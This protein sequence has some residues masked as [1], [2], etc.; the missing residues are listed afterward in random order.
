M[1]QATQWT[2]PEADI[3]LSPRGEQQADELVPALA[4]LPIQRVLVSPYL[5]ARETAR[6]A[7]GEINLPHT[8]LHPL[9]ERLSGDWRD[10]FVTLEDADACMATWDF[11]PHGGESIL[12]AVIRA[13]R[14]LHEHEAPQNTIVFAHGRLLAGLLTA[15]DDADTT[16]SIMPTANCAVDAREIAPGTWGRLLN[17]LSQQRPASGHSLL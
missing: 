12:D 11:R 4:D 5:R 15:I 14:A 3:P 17:T 10:W 7:M 6:R 8:I 16:R 9:H 1:A 2:G 13:L